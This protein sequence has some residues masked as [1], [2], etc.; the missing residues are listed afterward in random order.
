[1]KNDL[2]D[3]LDGGV[4]EFRWQALNPPRSILLNLSFEINEVRHISNDPRTQVTEHGG[5]MRLE[6]GVQFSA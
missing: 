4:E 5:L 6:Q 2:A 1:M 3:G